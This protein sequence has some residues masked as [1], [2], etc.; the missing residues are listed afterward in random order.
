[1]T[2]RTHR[3]ARTPESHTSRLVVEQLEDRV[4]PAKPGISLAP[5]DGQFAVGADQGANG[6]VKVL[7]ANVVRYS[8]IAFPG[9]NG[10]VRVATGD[11]NGDGTDDIAVGAGFGANHGH[12]KVY[13]GTTGA[14]ITSFFSFQGFKG[15]V[16]VDIGDVN[17][18]GKGDLIVGSGPSASHVKVFDLA[19]GGTEIAS[20]IAYSGSVGGV[21]VTSGDLD[22]DGDEEVITG[23]AIGGAHVKAFSVGTGGAVTEVASFVAYSG[24]AGGIDVDAADLRNNDGIA[25]VAVSPLDKGGGEEVRLFDLSTGTPTLLGSFVPKFP[26][27]D[28]G[29]RLASG[30]ADGDGDDDI[31]VAGGPGRGA[32]VKAFDAQTFTEIKDFSAFPGFQGGVFVG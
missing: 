11:V 16:D 3:I 17:G 22:G 8:F 13:D 10:G 24:Y 19:A 1:M 28:R 31:I 26:G 6:H 2:T 25:E 14:E 5:S 21:T 29:V 12:V 15:G 9:F 18:D 27:A 32:K 23:S 20:F 4:T 30:D 7:K